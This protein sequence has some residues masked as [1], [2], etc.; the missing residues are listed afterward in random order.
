MIELGLQK[1][2]DILLSENLYDD[3]RAS[4]IAY[5]LYEIL[6]SRGKIFQAR[7]LIRQTW[8]NEERLLGKCNSMTICSMMAAGKCAI[9]L[10]DFVEAEET[11]VGITR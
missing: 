4:I 11:V 1:A 7:D 5:G 2:V 8:K 9:E 10:G 6:F 3:P